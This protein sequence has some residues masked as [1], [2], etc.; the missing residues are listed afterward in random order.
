MPN[1]LSLNAPLPQQGLAQASQKSIYRSV[2]D[3][4][5]RGGVEPRAKLNLHYRR[6][7]E[8]ARNR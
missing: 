1:E 8:Q 7:S 4:A 2:V 5:E 3:V 6:V